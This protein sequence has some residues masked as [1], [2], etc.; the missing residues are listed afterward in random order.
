VVGALALDLWW[1]RGLDNALWR[2]PIWAAV[3]FGVGHALWRHRRDA[4]GSASAPI[5]SARAWGEAGVAG[6][7]LAT[8]LWVLQLVLA[9]PYDE[10]QPWSFGSTP[11]SQL[12]WAVSRFGGVVA[13]QIGL[14]L[15]LRPVLLELVPRRGLALLLGAAIFGLLHLPSPTLVFVTFAAGGVWL[16]L[17]DRGQRLAPL[18]VLHLG[19]A[20]LAEMS[21][22]PRLSW[23]MR[24][25]YRAYQSA[26]VYRSLADPEV[27][28]LLRYVTSAEF[29]AEHPTEQAFLEG[30]Y[31]DLLDRPPDVEGVAS[32]QTRLT[33]TSR[34]EVARGFVGSEEFRARRDAAD[35]R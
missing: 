18:V 5:S 24:V 19:L 3:F 6:L 35:D 12:V 21:L 4:V 16:W 28:A 32:W 23:D 29:E 25:G 30:L 26:P 34:A 27:R 15:F 22:P 7:F 13:Q 2:L 10:L 1:V 17:Y 31:R 9:E 33:R 20:I 8:A 14:Q 11:T